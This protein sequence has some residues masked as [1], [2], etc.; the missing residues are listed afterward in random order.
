[1]LTLLR[2]LSQAGTWRGLW[3]AIRRSGK[4]S[5]ARWM[6]LRFGFSLAVCCL[7][8][9][10]EWYQFRGLLHAD[11]FFFLFFFGAVVLFAGTLFAISRINE[12]RERIRME[13]D[14]PSVG[15]QI[16]RDLFRET[17]VFACLLIRSAS[18]RGMEKELPPT[19]EVITRRS[20]IERLRSRGLLEEMQPLVRDL[21]LAPDGHW[22]EEQKRRVETLWES[23]DVLAHV[24]G[25]ADL[26]S[27]SHKP[28]YSLAVAHKV[29]A[30]RKPESLAVQPSWD[31]RP[32]RDVT[33]GWLN[34]C[35]IEIIARG[36]YAEADEAISEEASGLREKIQ[37]EGYTEDLL[38]DAKTISE[39]P[40]EVLWAVAHRTVRRVETLHIAVNVVSGEQPAAKVRELIA[41]AF[42]VSEAEP[43]AV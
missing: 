25:L 3:V 43:E 33:E 23:F 34:R 24:L 19:I 26:G 8:I 40:R 38:I 31:L 15:P 35:W 21:L 20:L 28:V 6:L 41:K 22:S 14:D 16:K 13:V 4:D 27:L 29:L 11:P 37:A 9:W 1:M 2:L 30:V 12:R 5:R 32:V 7:W 18:E 39:V 10:G 17:F 36:E 42:A